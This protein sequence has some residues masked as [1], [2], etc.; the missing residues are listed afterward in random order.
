LHNETAP[1]QLVNEY[2][3]SKYAGEA[4][5]LDLANALVVRTNFTG[6]RGWPQPT[7]FEWAAD[8]LRGHLPMTLFDDYFTSTIDA[9]ALA[10][11]LFDLIQKK[12]A[13]LLNVASR[14]VASKKQF[15][16]ALARA[17]SIDLDR[18]TSGSVKNLSVP[19]AESLGLDVSRAEA[20]LGYA[21]PDLTS[22]AASLANSER[23]R[24]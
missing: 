16:E 11:A 21:L 10:R 20:I 9:A 2:A 1:V 3:R 17:M 7:F 22:V 14:Q 19:R 23:E 4:A 8:S 24:P 5:S 18:A 15:V 6:P 13:G 12:A